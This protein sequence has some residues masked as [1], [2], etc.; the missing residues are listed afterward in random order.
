[1]INAIFKLSGFEGNLCPIDC[2]ILMCGDLASAA[3]PVIVG[4][5]QILT[6]TT[7]P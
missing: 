2:L 1:M 4:Q 3:I 5:T 7:A 6:W